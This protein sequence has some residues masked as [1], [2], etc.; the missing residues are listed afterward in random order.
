MARHFLGGSR[1][2]DLLWLYSRA[3]GEFSS[4]QDRSNLKNNP[5]GLFASSVLTN[6]RLAPRGIGTFASPLGLTAGIHSVHSSFPVYIA[7]VQFSSPKKNPQCCVFTYGMHA[8]I[9]CR[10]TA[11]HS[12]LCK[13]GCVFGPLCDID[14][15]HGSAFR[16]SPPLS[17]VSGRVTK[18]IHILARLIRLPVFY[19]S[20]ST[21]NNL[22]SQIVKH[23]C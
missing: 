22:V 20:V 9:H 14:V 6:L 15:S 12:Q 16:K 4:D 23:H 17:F 11:A 2:L 10:A 13:F 21:T 1:G 18:S 19:F 7:C 5:P 3:V 8:V